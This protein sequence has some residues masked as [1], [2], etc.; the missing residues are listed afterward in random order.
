M[1][2]TADS[3]FQFDADSTWLADDQI[4]IGHRS[5]MSQEL[6]GLT[7]S[8]ETLWQVGLQ[9][10]FDELDIHVEQLVGGKP[11]RLR[12]KLNKSLNH[13]QWFYWDVTSQTYK[14]AELPAVGQKRR[15]E[16]VF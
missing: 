9:R 12:I 6:V 13:Y 5:Y 2:L 3:I 11:K 1:Y 16:G 14:T 15:I 10:Q 7:R 8:V 4:P